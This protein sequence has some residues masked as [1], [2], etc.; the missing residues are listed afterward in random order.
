MDGVALAGT[1]RKLNPATVAIWITIHRCGKYQAQAASLCVAGVWNNLCKV[2]RP[3]GLQAL[4]NA[5]SQT[6]TGLQPLQPNPNLA[7]TRLDGW[8]GMIWF[9][10]IWEIMGARPARQSSQERMQQRAGLPIPGSQGG[11]GCLPCHCLLPPADA[12]ES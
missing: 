2:V 6:A 5:K 7:A 12:G 8:G 10:M 11:D 3:V 9:T 1:I 4:G